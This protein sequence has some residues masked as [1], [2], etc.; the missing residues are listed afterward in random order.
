M[1][2]ELPESF[3]PKS[4]LVANYWRKVHNFVVMMARSY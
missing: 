4:I 2:D 3:M 1:A